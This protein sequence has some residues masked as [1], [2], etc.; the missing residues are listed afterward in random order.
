ML[1]S[2]TRLSSDQHIPEIPLCKS[3]VH[4]EALV[5]IWVQR[6]LDYDRCLRL[7]PVDGRD[8]ERIGKPCNVRRQSLFAPRRLHIPRPAL[9][10][11]ED[12]LNTSLLYS[13][14]A[15]MTVTEC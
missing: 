9:A 6:L 15:A 4:V 11:A 14:S 5:P 2:F 13:P 7:L 3:G 8:S 1:S 10:N 12:V